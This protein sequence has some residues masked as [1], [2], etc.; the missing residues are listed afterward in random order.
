M[1][2][3]FAYMQNLFSVRQL[4]GVSEGVISTG[5]LGVGSGEAYRACH[6][7]RERS[8]EVAVRSLMGGLA[9]ATQEKKKLLTHNQ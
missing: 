8:G 3:I 2:Y 5:D 9:D 6:K 4:M 7:L 1:Q